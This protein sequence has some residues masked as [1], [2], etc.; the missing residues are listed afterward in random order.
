MKNKIS[1]ISLIFF[2][3]GCNTNP[4]ESK[5]SDNNLTIDS[6][7]IQIT[8]YKPKSEKY[9]EKIKVIREID[10]N[11]RKTIY[12][13]TDLQENSDTIIIDDNN[14]FLNST[15]LKHVDEKRINYDG[16]NILI[17]KHLYNNTYGSSNFY[18]DDSHKLIIKKSISSNIV[19][20]YL[21]DNVPVN[22]HSA[23]KSDTLFFKPKW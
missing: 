7:S 11:Y 19:V 21:E 16:K 3:Y 8:Y 23:I 18:F 20:E 14:I 5:L 4:K 17:K 12:F 2:I 10:N 9:S 1:I 6:D 22:I 13:Y 15:L